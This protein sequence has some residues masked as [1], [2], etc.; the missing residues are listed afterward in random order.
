GLATPMAIVVGAGRGAQ[1]GVLYRNAEALERTAAVSVLFVDKT[2]TLTEGKSTVVEVRPEE[3]YSERDLISAASAVEQH[4]EHPLAAAVVRVARERGIQSF[5]T[6]NFR[7]ITGKGVQAEINGHTLRVGSAEWLRSVGVGGVRDT[8][9]EESSVI[10]VS[11]DGE[12]LGFLAIA[13]PIKTNARQAIRILE[14]QGFHVRMLTGDREAVASA[15]A[16]RTGVREYEAGVTPERKREVVREARQHGA[17]VAMAGDG[18]ND[19]PALADADV[20][21]AMGGG[22]DI[23]MQAGNVTLLRG[24]LYGIVRARKL[25][26]A[27]VRNIRQNLFFAFIYN[28]IGVPIAAGVLYPVFGIVLSPMFAAAAMSLSSV[29]VI[30]NALRLRRI[31]L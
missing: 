30:A 19:A 4:S 18:I 22:T 15:V 11:S 28:A 25:S 8:E 17:V 7:S 13:D 29:S 26:V 10:H 3:G 5:R 27:V 20:G 24:D 23:A 1:A 16:R 12:Y 6:E 31:E 9:A 2:G 14:E 21:I